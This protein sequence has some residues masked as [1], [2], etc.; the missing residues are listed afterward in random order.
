MPKFIIR[1]SEITI[2]TAIVDAAD[3]IEAGNIVKS[4]VTPV[5]T[6]AVARNFKELYGV[7]PC[8]DLEQHRTTKIAASPTAPEKSLHCCDSMPGDGHE[9][10]C[11]Y[12]GEYD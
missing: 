9:I 8:V 4:G 6:T 5:N 1:W 3:R 2:L 12:G 7:R 11:A 10:D